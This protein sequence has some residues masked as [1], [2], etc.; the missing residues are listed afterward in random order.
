LKVSLTY[1]FGME[2]IQAKEMEENSNFD[3]EL[4][5]PELPF[6]HEDTLGEWGTMSN[7]EIKEKDKP[8]QLSLF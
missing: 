3:N 2:I 1:H 5:T 4:Q 6:V 8:E 7:K